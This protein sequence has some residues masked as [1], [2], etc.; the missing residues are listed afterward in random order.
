MFGWH[1]PALAAL[2]YA[3]VAMAWRGRLYL[4]IVLNKYRGVSA[5]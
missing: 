2:L 1:L 3:I 4:L 5:G